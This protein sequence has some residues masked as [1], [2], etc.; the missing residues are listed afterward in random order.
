MRWNATPRFR[1]LESPVA[2]VAV[3]QDVRKVNEIKRV[4]HASGSSSDRLDQ[5]RFYVTLSG[6]PYFE[7]GL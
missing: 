3:L 2:W 7:P 5:V 1:S 6:F 4:V